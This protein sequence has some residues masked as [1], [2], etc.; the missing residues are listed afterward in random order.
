[1]SHFKM[2]K[3]K[4]RKALDIIKVVSSIDCGTGRSTLLNLFRSQVRSCLALIGMQTNM[5]Y[6]ICFVHG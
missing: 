6:L 2:L 5:F 4:Y 1:M 3:D